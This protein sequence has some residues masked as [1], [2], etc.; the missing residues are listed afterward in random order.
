MRHH[1]EKYLESTIVFTRFCGKLI[2]IGS[3]ETAWN[4]CSTELMHL[5]KNVKTTLRE[6]NPKQK[7]Q[8][9]SFLRQFKTALGQ[10]RNCS[11]SPEMGVDQDLHTAT[12]QVTLI[13]WRTA[14]HTPTRVGQHRDA[15]KADRRQH[16]AIVL[17]VISRIPPIKGDSSMASYSDNKR[18]TN[19]T[20]KGAAAVTLWR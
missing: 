11:C 14:A 1:C 4:S 7:H 5:V 19:K 15:I 12:R 18:A 16:G 13:I 6:D 8:T 17:V 2:L 3:R 9:M 10:K 20:D